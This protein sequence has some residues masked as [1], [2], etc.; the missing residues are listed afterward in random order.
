MVSERMQRQ[1]D[2]LLDQSSEALTSLTW[3][4][5]P[6]INVMEGLDQLDVEEHQRFMHL[7]AE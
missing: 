1:I 3:A 6:I 7:A 5:I 4:R 2:G